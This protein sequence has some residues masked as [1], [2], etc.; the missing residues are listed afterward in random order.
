VLYGRALAAEA[1]GDNTARDEYLARVRELKLEYDEKGAV[2]DVL[3][4]YVFGEVAGSTGE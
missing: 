4:G 3:T 1:D 2:A